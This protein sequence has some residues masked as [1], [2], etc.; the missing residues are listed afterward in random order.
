M[1]ETARAHGVTGCITISTTPPDAA[2]AL[3]IALRFPNVW[4][5]AGVTSSEMPT[6]RPG[7]AQPPAAPRTVTIEHVIRRFIGVSVFSK[8]ACV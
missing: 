6:Q 2:E 5:S 3:G 1:L 8:S 4:S 7:P